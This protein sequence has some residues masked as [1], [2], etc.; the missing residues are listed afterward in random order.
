MRP[1]PFPSKSIMRALLRRAQY[2]DVDQLSIMVLP[3]LQQGKKTPIFL[4]I[5]H[6]VQAIGVF[7]QLFLAAIKLFMSRHWC[8][9]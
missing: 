6:G 8:R 9:E 3:L 5:D 7:K 4:Q 2:I 1:R